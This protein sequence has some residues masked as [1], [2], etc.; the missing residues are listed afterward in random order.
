[1]NK[2]DLARRLARESHRSRAQAA[3]ELDSLLYRIFKDLKRSQTAAATEAAGT[4]L[5]SGTRNESETK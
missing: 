5:K 1:M 2:K 3:D 4:E